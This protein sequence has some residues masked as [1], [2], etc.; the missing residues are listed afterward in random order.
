MHSSIDTLRSPIIVEEP[1]KPKA[2]PFE[3]LLPQKLRSA[4][5][6][7]L[8]QLLLAVLALTTYHVQIITR[9]SSGSPLWYIWIA[10]R[11]RDSPKQASIILRWMIIYGLVQATLYSSFLPPA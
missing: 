11:T 5:G 4:A 7:A 8:P 3:R 6:L 1:S 10:A 9:I 2:A